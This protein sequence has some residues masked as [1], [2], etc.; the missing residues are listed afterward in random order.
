MVSLQFN[1]N[2]QRA[3]VVAN[4]EQE[5]EVILSEKCFTN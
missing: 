1:P 2:A 4:F 3:H 5:L